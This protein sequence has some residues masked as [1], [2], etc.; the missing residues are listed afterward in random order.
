MR[1]LKNLAVIFTT[2]FLGFNASLAQ[3]NQQDVI[4]LKNGSIIRG[5]ILE[6]IPN[7]SVKIEVVG[8]NILVFQMEELEKMTKGEKPESVK[9][10]NKIQS[11]VFYN[12]L[13]PGILI[14]ENAYGLQIDP[15]FQI[16]NGYRFNRF[17]SLGLGI[18]LESISEFTVLP[19]FLESRGF[20]FDK[21]S[22]PF[23]YIGA[24][25]GFVNRGYG[26][27]YSY[28]K[29]KGGAMANFGV[30]LRTPIA[31]SFS[32]TTSIGYRYQYAYSIS[33][34]SWGWPEP[35]TNTVETINHF[36]RIYV[37]FGFMF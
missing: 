23:Y 17:L 32:F 11:K 34:Y 2:V 6:I 3:S 21:P 9:K 8:N 1:V 12:V 29:S 27:G 5:N 33:S 13:S 22:T 35:Q 36:N 7:K 37:N 31:K 30:G 15:S 16:I 14:G 25:Y 10:D 24:G 20:L 26:Y 19:V 28:E 4:M 18:G